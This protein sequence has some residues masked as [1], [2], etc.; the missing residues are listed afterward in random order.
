MNEKLKKEMNEK[1]YKAEKRLEEIYS[2]LFV[3]QTI[4]YYV[5]EKNIIQEEI[6]DILDSIESLKGRLYEL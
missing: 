1:L 6:L 3:E 5:N 2:G 4:D